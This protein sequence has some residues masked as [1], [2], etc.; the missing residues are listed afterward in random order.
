MIIVSGTYRTG[1]SLMC[2][3]MDEAGFD[4]LGEKFPKAWMGKNTE[5]N[6]QGFYESRWVDAGLND[7]TCKFT[8]EKLRNKAIKVFTHGLANTK[9]DYV[10]RVVLMIRDWREQDAS[11][12]HLDRINRAF[13]NMNQAFYPPGYVYLIQYAKFLADYRK[14][15]YPTLIVDYGD[16]LNDLA[17]TV[18]KLRN[19]IGM[20]RFDLAFNRVKPKEKPPLRHDDLNDDYHRFMD[21]FYRKM[22][23][24]HL[25]AAFLNETQGWINKIKPEVDRVNQ[26]RNA[27]AEADRKAAAAQ[28]ASAAAE[29]RLQPAAG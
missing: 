6:K 5:L 19:F 3:I 17:T 23:S 27:K 16:V 29:T 8:P 10:D 13:I 25:E 11:A 7:K 9:M 15:K 18:K 4:V 20:G 21:R 26:E 12:K 14:R 2:Q 24:G 1:T 28:K 22:K